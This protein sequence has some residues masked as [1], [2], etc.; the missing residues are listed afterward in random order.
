M[1]TETALIN[2]GFIINFTFF[3]VLSIINKGYSISNTDSF[4]K[5]FFKM[6]NGAMGISKDS[7]VEEI[8]LGLEDE[9][10]DKG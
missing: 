5:R 2:S 10:E 9:E 1:L 8:D 6:F 3:K 4:A 7:T